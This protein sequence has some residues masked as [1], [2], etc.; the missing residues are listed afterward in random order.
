M[1]TVI[2]TIGF[3]EKTAREFFTKL[4][5]AGVKTVIDIRLNNASQLAGFTKEQ[6]LPYFLQEIAGIKYI[7]KPELAPTKDI[8]DAYRKKDIDWSEYERRF[9]QLLIE[10]QLGD[11][12]TQQFVD[13][14]CLLCSETKPDK[15]HRRLVAE[16]LR[17]LWEDVKI[18]H[19]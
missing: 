14:S 1:E 6:D 15:C 3:A 18:V 9:C 8:L 12:I 5:D 19:L 4:K 16:Y 13:K 7:H 2:Y 17:E 11:I 10:R